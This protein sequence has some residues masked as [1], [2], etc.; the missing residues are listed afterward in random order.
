[1]KTEN[2]TI[3]ELFCS[4]SKRTTIRCLEVTEARGSAESIGNVDINK[5][6]QTPDKAEIK[7]KKTIQNEAKEAKYVV[8]CRISKKSINAFET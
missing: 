2:G 3:T 6:C 7:K 1:M 4:T 8:G 5:K